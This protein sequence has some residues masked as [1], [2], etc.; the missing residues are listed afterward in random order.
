M[1]TLPDCSFTM[2]YTDPPFNTG[3]ATGAAGR[4]RPGR[5]DGQG[6]ARRLRRPALHHRLLAESSF[7]DTFDD[8]LAWLVPRLQ[9]MRR[10]LAPEARST[11]TS[12]T[13]R[14]T[15]EG[16][17]GR[18]LRSRRFLNEL[19]WAYDYGAVAHALAREARHDP[20]LRARRR[21]P[22]LRPRGGRPQALHGARASSP[23]SRRR[24]KLPTDVWW[25]TIVPTDGARR[26]GTR[27]RS[28]RAW[29]GGWCWRPPARQPRLDPFAGCGTLGASRRSAAGATCWSTRQ[30]EAVGV[31]E[32]RLAPLRAQ[33]ACSASPS[34]VDAGAAA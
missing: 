28:G 3:P 11:S 20:R 31:M 13:A 7:G 29:C 9:D 27:R 19:I 33:N 23:R 8:Y 17:A 32:R 1:P 5:A 15:T 21:A 30:P 10:V 22:P 18:D 14:P 4:S 6:D 12:T 34:G 26:P 16:A 2:V 25:H 24:G